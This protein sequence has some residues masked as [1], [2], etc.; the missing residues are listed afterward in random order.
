VR[1]T[2]VLVETNWVVDVVA[3]A[4]LQSPQAFQLLSRAEAGEFKLHLPAICLTEA[5]ET[6]PRRFTPRALSADLRK[7]FRWISCMGKPQLY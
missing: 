7:F 5:S 2:A 3:P 6:V 4:H 1:P